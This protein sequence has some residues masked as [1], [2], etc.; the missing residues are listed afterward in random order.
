VFEQDIKP[1]DFSNQKKNDDAKSLNSLTQFNFSNKKK[2]SLNHIKAPIKKIK[3][4]VPYQSNAYDSQNSYFRLNQTDTSRSIS[5]IGRSVSPSPVRRIKL[6]DRK[7]ISSQKP[8][9][10]RRFGT[11]IYKAENKRYVSQDQ[12]PT[13][14]RNDSKSG[15]TNNL[16]RI[17]KQS[18]KRENTINQASSEEQAESDYYYVNKKK[19]MPSIGKVG[20]LLNHIKT[21]IETN[22]FTNT[23]S[24]NNKYEVSE[25]SSFMQSQNPKEKNTT[26]TEVYNL[27]FYPNKNSLKSKT[28][29]KLNDNESSSYRYTKKKIQTTPNFTKY[30][31]SQLSNSKKNYMNSKTNLRVLQ[32][33]SA[34]ES[35]EENEMNFTMKN[36]DEMN[37]QFEIFKNQ[38][39]NNYSGND[40]KFTNNYYS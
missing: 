32:S 6:E 9:P 19:K 21:N 38:I 17:I 13:I 20:D 35:E 30:V 2:I 26:T 34:F 16:N 8:G 7:I 27:D 1:S 18:I 36:E 10:N 40:S 39:K 28:F 5:R 12:K 31:S 4:S 14:S 23:N 29:D 33:E 25:L 15:F 22:N 37:N 24:D 3:Y 11:K